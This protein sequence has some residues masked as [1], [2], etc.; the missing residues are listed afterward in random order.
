MNTVMP[1]TAASVRRTRRLAIWVAITAGLSL[2]AIFVAWLATKGQE[3]ATLRG[4]SGPVRCV[5]IDPERRL[6]V[7]A[8]DDGRIRLWNLDTNRSVGAIAGHTP[9]AIA[10]CLLGGNAGIASIGSDKKLSFWSVPDGQAIRSVDIPTTPECVASSTD[11]QFLAVGCSDNQIRTFNRRD[12]K[13]SRVLAGHTK[14]V[15]CLTFTPDGSRLV[16]AGADGSI[17]FWDPVTGIAKERIDVG[18]HPVH[19]LAVSS[20]GTRLVAAISGAGLRSWALPTRQE[21]QAFGMDAGMAWSVAVSP[22]G[23]YLASG[24]E[25]GQVKLWDAA[26]CRLIR[27][28]RGHKG[29]V[30]SIAFAPD[31]ETVFSAA[32]DGAVKRWRVKPG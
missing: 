8:G 30:L 24:H 16:S 15:H 19:A 23:K 2:V 18:H 9:K 25:D 3:L 27:S 5:T 14:P 22:D 13:Q 29:V 7:T 32:G 4:H 12:E 17:R 10:V 31:G 11:G 21:H 26:D 1:E 28:Y 20:D 6:V